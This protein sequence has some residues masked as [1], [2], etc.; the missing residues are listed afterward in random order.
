M[1]RHPT[2]HLKPLRHAVGCRHV[3]ALSGKVRAGSPQDRATDATIERRNYPLAAGRGRFAGAALT[4]V[5][6]AAVLATGSFVLV[7]VLS[8]VFAFAGALAVARVRSVR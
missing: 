8:A 1:W 2:T 3:G 6:V 5:A 7:F 4:F